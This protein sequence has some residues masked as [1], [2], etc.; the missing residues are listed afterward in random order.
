M[1]GYWKTERKGNTLYMQRPLHAM[2]ARIIYTM[3]R[4]GVIDYNL[5]EKTF[6]ERIYYVYYL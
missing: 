4:L 6:K 3:V 5:Y 1:K 2:Y